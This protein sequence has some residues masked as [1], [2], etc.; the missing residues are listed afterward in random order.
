MKNKD[1]FSKYW[2]KKCDTLFGKIFHTYYATQ[3]IVSIYA[4]D[5]CSGRIEMAHLIPRQNY[6]WRWDLQNVIPLCSNHHRFSRKC[7]SHN[8]PVVFSQVL[9]ENFPVYY[10]FV[11][12]NRWANI[13]RK[14][15]LPF[16]FQEKY[17]ELT[18]LLEYHEKRNKV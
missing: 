6:L 17:Q 16:N 14:A 8:S 9:E 2:L 5:Q 13:T 7:S 12:N 1:P 4:P 3:C 11:R 18:K 15:E 10:E